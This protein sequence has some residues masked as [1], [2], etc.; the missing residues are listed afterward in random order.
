MLHIHRAERADGLVEALRELTAEPPPDP[1]APEVVAVPTHGMERWLTQR[2]SDRLGATPGRSDGVCANV[3]FPSPRRL[4]GAAVAAACGEDPEADP[5]LPERAVWPL[6]GVVEESLAE[7]WLATLAAHLG[8]ADDVARRGRRF[9]TLRHV[10]D[11]FDAYA[12]HRPAMLRAWAAGD[13]VDGAGTVLRGEAAWQ[14]ELWRRLRAR[15]GRA[16]PAERR[17]D[18]CLWLAA[19]PSLSDLRC[20]ARRSL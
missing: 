5:W 11:L 20:A 6:L 17:G 4:V 14:A 15:I 18:A 13:D 19:D 8:A 1:F 12:L 3:D 7:P 10:A 2:L 9:G 16:D